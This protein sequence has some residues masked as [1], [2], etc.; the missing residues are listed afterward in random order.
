MTGLIVVILEECRL[1]DFE[2]EMQLNPLSMGTWK[3]AALCGLWRPFQEVPEETV[4]ASWLETILKI[5]WQRTW[6]LFVL[7]VRIFWRLN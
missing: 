3:M 6:L 7:V 4:L 1:W 5:F 2:L